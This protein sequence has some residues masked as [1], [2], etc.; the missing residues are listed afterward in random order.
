MTSGPGELAELG[1]EHP[2]GVDVA[3]REQRLHRPAE[4]DA[5][6]Q[7]GEIFRV[8]PDLND[9]WLIDAGRRRHI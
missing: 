2:D 1:V 6:L 8:E 4:T 5:R 7:V 3:A 9:A